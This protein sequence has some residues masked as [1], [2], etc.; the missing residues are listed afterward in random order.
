MIRI[1]PVSTEVDPQSAVNPG[2]TRDRSWIAPA[3]IRIEQGSILI[4]PV[5]VRVSTRDRPA[6]TWR[7]RTDPMSIRTDPRWIRG[8]SASTRGRSGSTKVE[9]RLDPRSTCD[10]HAVGGRSWIDPGSAF[11][12]I[13]QNIEEH[14]AQRVMCT[15][16]L[17]VRSGDTLAAPLCAGTENRSTF[18]NDD[19][20][21]CGVAALGLRNQNSHWHH[22]D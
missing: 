9:S 2:L 7:S 16:E 19:F 4:N 6:D 13:R 15:A 22:D 8:R 14:F 5:P 17:Q 21:R 11:I 18:R 3:S 20:S 12:I 1:D 10:R